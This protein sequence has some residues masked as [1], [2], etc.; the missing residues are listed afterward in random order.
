MSWGTLFICAVQPRSLQS[1]VPDFFLHFKKV[2]NVC[3]LDP[4]PEHLENSPG[5]NFLDLILFGRP[6]L[7]R[8]PEV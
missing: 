2:V 3:V 6:V 5:G 7:I 8:L 1:F 4:I